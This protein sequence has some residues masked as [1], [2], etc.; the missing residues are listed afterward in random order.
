MRLQIPCNL[1]MHHQSNVN[2]RGHKIQHQS[3]RKLQESVHSDYS[4][5]LRPASITYLLTQKWFLQNGNRP[6]QYARQRTPMSPIS[7]ISVSTQNATN[8]FTQLTLSKRSSEIEVR[9]KEEKLSGPATNSL[10]KHSEISTYV[11]IITA[12]PMMTVLSLCSAALKA[13]L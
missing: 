9:I 11:Q 5:H 2:T 1:V 8:I 13:E 12:S 6:S 7:N 4:S 3:H 10:T